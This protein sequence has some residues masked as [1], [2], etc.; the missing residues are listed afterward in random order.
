MKKVIT[1]VLVFALL[2]VPCLT[3]CGNSK[4]TGEV[5]VYNWGEYIDESIFDKFEEETGIK[6]DS[7]TYPNNESMYSTLKTGGA[8]YDV[9]IPSDYMVLETHTG[10]YARKD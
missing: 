3:G 2:C 6:V 9:I 8:S 5:N 4:Y 1:L 10:G 7:Q